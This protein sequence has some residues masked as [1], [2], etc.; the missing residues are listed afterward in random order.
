MNSLSETESEPEQFPT[1]P[2]V[3]SLE[4]KP[5]RNYKKKVKV[6][7]PVEVVEEAPSKPKR[8]MTEEHKEKMRLAREASKARKALAQ[9]PEPLTEPEEP[10]AEPEV[11][12][13]RKYTRK[14]KAEVAE[15]AEPKVI[16]KEVHHHYNEPKAKKATGEK[17][18]RK[19]RVKKE[20]AEPKQVVPSVDFV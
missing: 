18:P 4:K 16:V 5:K 1:E 12:T 8:V 14:P 6:V 11:K 9:K 19:P 17:A 10:Q 2:V 3:E 13:K 15:V 7:E 20:V